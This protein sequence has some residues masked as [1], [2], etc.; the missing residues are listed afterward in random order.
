[1]W[2][3]L[4]ALGIFSVV[5]PQNFEAVTFGQDAQSEATARAAKHQ[6][7]SDSARSALD[8]ATPTEGAAQKR[9]DSVPNPQIEPLK[10]R[11]GEQV[12]PDSQGRSLI[13]GM[14]VQEAGHG[15]VKVVDVGAATPAYEAGIRK[16]DQIV[17]FQNFK[18]NDYRKWIDGMR[19]VATAAKDGDMLTIVVMRDGN[20]V[21]TKIR[22]PESH[23][24][25]VQLPLGPP[26]GQ[27]QQGVEPP[28]A[29]IAGTETE[30]ANT[31]NVAI[32]NS[33]P[34]ANFFGDQNG[35]AT[36][37]GMAELYRVANSKRD[38]N[39]AKSL[40]AQ[41]PNS[42]GARIGLAGFRNDPNGMVVMVDVGGLEPGNYTVGIGDPTAVMN[43]LPTNTGD[44][45][46]K[47]LP[48]PTQPQSNSQPVQI[49]RSVLANV[50]PHAD[51]ASTVTT[52]A[53]G[54]GNTTT[55]PT[56]GTTDQTNQTSNG[57]STGK[58]AQLH[59]GS[60]QNARPAGA[61]GINEVGSLTIDQS[62][63]GRMQHVVEGIRVRNV[64]GQA[65]IIS[66]SATPA[67]KTLPPSLDSSVDPNP[68]K[69]EDSAVAPSGAPGN[70]LPA[71]AGIIRLI[72]DR[73]PAPPKGGQ[74]A[75]PGTSPSSANSPPVAAPAARQ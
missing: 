24:G 67:A 49:S 59:E 32:E 37:R 17:S 10:R 41:A 44:V 6:A 35:A 62:G 15:E 52:P 64:V 21:T 66:T 38:R 74:A 29:A 13:L 8:I 51:A 20:P 3:T 40:N 46:G 26:P 33:G 1:M 45:N 36:E 75:A 48:A 18:A 55:T 23:V 11:A 34:F 25:P 60:E 57:Q 56:T 39:G 69:S 47:S 14:K 58:N 4:L 19:R 28:P 70:S 7:A 63:T 43:Q 71:A 12:G 50:E 9:H 68:S 61:P 73:S 27:Q 72:S 65:L 22:V 53:T 42:H 54:P 31:N 2:R 16:G 30:A 5:G